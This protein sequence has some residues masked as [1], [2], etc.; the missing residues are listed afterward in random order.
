MCISPFSFNKLTSDIKPLFKV[1]QFLAINYDVSV[2]SQNTNYGSTK[3]SKT[4]RETYNE[5][6]FR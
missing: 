6:N 2:Y 3:I 1:R 5:I 4:I